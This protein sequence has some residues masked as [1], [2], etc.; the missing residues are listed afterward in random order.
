[1]FIL[2]CGQSGLRWR[3]ETALHRGLYL[4]TRSPVCFL[5]RERNRVPNSLLLR[6]FRCYYRRSNIS[7]TNIRTLMDAR[8]QISRSYLGPESR[9]DSTSIRFDRFSTILL[10]ASLL[11][12]SFI[13]FQR[14]HQHDNVRPEWISRNGVARV[15]VIFFNGTILALAETR[16]ERAKP[17]CAGYASEACRS[18]RI[19]AASWPTITE[20]TPTVAL[21]RLFTCHEQRTVF[22]RDDDRSVPPLYESSI[23]SQRWHR[24]IVFE[25]RKNALQRKWCKKS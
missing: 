20:L 13:L 15:D 2:F 16:R 17:T 7:A 25:A 12:F 8:N 18:T 23:A 1:M 9:D 6:K 14:V 11:S 3:Q 4:S 5:R 19:A 24:G 22:K 21:R 10:Q